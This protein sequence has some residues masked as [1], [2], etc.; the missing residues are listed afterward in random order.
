MYVRAQIAKAVKSIVRDVHT[1]QE[2]TTHDI[3]DL[4]NAIHDRALRL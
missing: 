1:A 3:A 4:K 2:A